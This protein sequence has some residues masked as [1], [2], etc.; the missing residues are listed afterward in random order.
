MR[1]GD[2]LTVGLPGEAALNKDFPVDRKGDVTL[3]GGRPGPW[4]PADRSTTRQNSIRDALSH[5]YRDLDKLSVSLKE[6][7]LPITVLG[8]VKTPGNVELAGDGNVQ[9]ALVAAGG[10]S[11]GAQLDRMIVT[12]ADGKREQ[13]DYKKYLDSGDPNDAAA[14]SAARRHFRSC[15]AA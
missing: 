4:S 13:F 6:R 8:Y 5:A 14:A 10:I 11:Q 12:H 2:V 1:I 9:M 15:V 7:K 3:A